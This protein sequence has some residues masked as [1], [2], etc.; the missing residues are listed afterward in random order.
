MGQPQLGRRDSL[1]TFIGSLQRTIDLQGIDVSAFLAYKETLIKYLERFISELV[2]ATI[3]IT[4]TLES[5]E[6]AGMV[7][8]LELAARRNLA[9]AFAPTEE[10]YQRSLRLWRAR[11][12]GLRAWFLHQP[13]LP[14]QAEILRARA[15]SSIPARF[16]R[17]QRRSTSPAAALLR[18]QP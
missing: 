2:I 7:R 6:E 18:A 16:W 10:D 12:D 11:W 5:I 3:A 17:P 15:R 4:A 1:Q 8:L 14:S 13:D 9:D